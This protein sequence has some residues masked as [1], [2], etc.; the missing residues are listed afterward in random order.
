MTKLARLRET[1]TWIAWVRLGAIVFALLEV[2][3]FSG[4]YPAGYETYA[5]A[6]TGIFIVRK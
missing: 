3:V 4:G 5:W 1:E 6:T 2:G